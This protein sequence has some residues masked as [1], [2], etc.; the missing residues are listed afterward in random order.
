MEPL[1]DE[2]I[3]PMPAR[4][5]R[6]SQVDLCFT[7]GWTNAPGVSLPADPVTMPHVAVMEERTPEEGIIC[8]VAF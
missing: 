3:A 1:P 6:I 8:T 7:F 5:K 4:A 2:D